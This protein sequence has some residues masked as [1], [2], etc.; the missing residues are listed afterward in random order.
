MDNSSDN[1]AFNDQQLEATKETYMK[2]SGSN[3]FDFE[4]HNRK[5]QAGGSKW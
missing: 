4:E 5:S 3:G 1:L 2:E